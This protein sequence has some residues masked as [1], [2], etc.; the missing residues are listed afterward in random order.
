MAQ[1]IRVKLVKSKIGC[2]ER[3]LATLVGLGLRNVN[4]QRVLENSAC[5]RGMLDKVKHLI[6]IDTVN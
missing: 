6:E 4:Q 2:N 5:V 1:K 3:Q